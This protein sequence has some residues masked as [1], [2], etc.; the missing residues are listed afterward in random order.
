MKARPFT[1]PLF[2]LASFCCSQLV[3]QV[4]YPNYNV[5]PIPPD[6]TG[7]GSSA[8]EIAGRITLGLNF[9][10]TLEAIGGETAWGNPLITKEQVLLAK[11]HGFNAIRLPAS[12][13]QYSNQQTA[14]IDSAWLD[15][16]KTVVQHCVESDLY[17]ILNIH[18]DGGWLENNVTPAKQ[19]ENNAK[20]KAFWQQIATHLRS[21]DERL[22]FASANEPNAST[23]AQMQVL[24]SYHQTFVDAVRSTGGRNAFRTLVVQGP[25]TDFERTHALMHEL[26]IDTVP[27]RMMAEVHFYTPFNF[28]LMD[29]DQSWGRQFYYWGQGYH[30]TT[31]TN[32]NAT[33]GEEAL[34]DQLFALMK[35]QFTD[36]GIPVVLGEYGAM[37]RSALTGAALELHLASRAHYLKYVTQKASASGLLPF[38]WDA[39]GMGNNGSAIFN[40]RALT[41]HDQ[42]AL[43]SLLA[44]AANPYW[45]SVEDP[46]T[47]ATADLDGDES[48]NLLELFLGTDPQDPLSRPRPPT[49]QRDSDQRFHFAL[50][51]S[52]HTH[53][54]LELQYSTDLLEWNPRPATLA[55]DTPTRLEYLS[56]DLPTDPATLF[57]RLKITP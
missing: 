34:V 51:R 48:P 53:A 17:V 44:G 49:L 32:R 6:L 36:K 57:F 1:R 10:N 31:D 8:I 45:A 9:G 20:Q 27:S 33:W 5:D 47:A 19:A 55:T 50:Q 7:M 3:A 18:W 25:E 56:P 42:L 35:Q 23:P 16:I 46:N 37:R 14:Q 39:G 22:L 41:V 24:L 29:A 11:Q 26:P 4:S 2:L 40:R 43:D 12:W 38:Y 13:N 15:R 21:F 52:A 54:N 30:S 28:T